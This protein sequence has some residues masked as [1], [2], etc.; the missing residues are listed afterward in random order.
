MTNPHTV[1]LEDVLDAFAMEDTHTKATLD[2]YLSAHPQFAI[3]LVELSRELLRADPSADG[4]LSTGDVAKI[5]AAWSRHEALRPGPAVD[6]FAALSPTRSREIAR[7][8]G[9]PRQVVTSFR[10][11]RI[12]GASVP[13][14]FLRRLA[15]ALAVTVADVLAWMAP[16]PGRALAHSHRTDGQPTSAVQLTFE[17][18]LIDAGVPDSDR[19]RILSQED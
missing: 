19:A 15:A 1:H 4:E 14:A 7:E 8:L 17:R 13:R 11:R 18:V 2:R 10:E 6:P 9:V 16:P 5:D 12:R 3:D